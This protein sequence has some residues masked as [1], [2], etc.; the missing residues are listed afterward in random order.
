[1]EKNMLDN[2]QY[3]IKTPAQAFKN[4]LIL[5]ITAETEE[6]SKECLKMAKDFAK[7]CSEETVERI[8]KEIEAMNFPM[9]DE[10]DD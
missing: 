7:G 1:M 5:A 2:L 4:A 10:Q 3:P 6:K 8:K 9:E